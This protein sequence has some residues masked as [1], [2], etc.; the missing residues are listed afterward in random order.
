MEERCGKEWTNEWI[1]RTKN[2]SESQ[3]LKDRELLA[4]VGSDREING[5]T[6]NPN[7]TKIK[8][9]LANGA[10]IDFFVP[11]SN[12][13]SAYLCN[14]LDFAIWARKEEISELFIKRFPNYRKETN[15]RWRSI[16]G[17]LFYANMFSAGIE[18]VK[19]KEQVH[20]LY[21]LLYGLKDDSKF[22]N[23]IE[24]IFKVYNP[25]TQ[26][27]LAFQ[28]VADK[29]RFQNSNVKKNLELLK[30]YFLND[31][32]YGP[33]F[34]QSALGSTYKIDDPICSRFEKN[35]K[36]V[37]VAQEIQNLELKGLVEFK[38]DQSG[39]IKVN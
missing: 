31:T 9:L 33:K 23:L 5:K 28:M 22:K 19:T 25:S 21:D 32:N 7:E 8:R 34:I 1:K 3:K 30:N 12:D 38:K 10:T 18:L 24:E 35:G 39:K 27:K 14:A 2:K 13:G 11:Y 6:S 20:P 16:L 15:G 36:K 26:V 4:E 17:E 29:N 37:W